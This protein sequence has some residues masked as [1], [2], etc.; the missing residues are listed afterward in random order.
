MHTHP[1]ALL[2][3][4]AR[5]L[6]ETALLPQQKQEQTQ[7][8]LRIKFERVKTEMEEQV[9]ELE[10]FL[11]EMEGGFDIL[12]PQDLNASIFELSSS[13]SPSSVPASLHQEMSERKEEE[14]EENE[15]EEEVL[16]WQSAGFS[17]GAEEE[18]DDMLRRY[19]IESSSYEL[20]ISFDKD[21]SRAEQE[22]NSDSIPLEKEERTEEKLESFS[23]NRSEEGS[24]PILECLRNDLRAVKRVYLPL[25]TEWYN[26]LLKVDFPRNETSV[27]GEGS[28]PLLLV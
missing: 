1:S 20:E 15:E 4:A 21:F 25:V 22:E 17:V 2:L 23:D 16:E 5:W 8:V 10:T 9:A 12:M 18:V 14:E 3:L 26:V 24:Q 28:S 11:R 6:S 19:G 27:A 7:K 13:S